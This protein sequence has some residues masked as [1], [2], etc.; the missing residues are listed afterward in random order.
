[1]KARVQ[2]EVSQVRTWAGDRPIA[3]V[4]V[5]RV[6]CPCMTARGRALA[7]VSS[8]ETA[9]EIADLHVRSLHT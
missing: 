3:L 4:I 6:F 5:W 2:A 9:F 8:W 7:V 1:M